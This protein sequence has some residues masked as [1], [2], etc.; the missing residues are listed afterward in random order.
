MTGIDGSLD[1]VVQTIR[2]IGPG[3]LAVVGGS[4][5]DTVWA[6]DPQRGE[7]VR[8]DGNARRVVGR[9][10]VPG[11]PTRLAATD[12]AVWVIGT[13]DDGGSLWR[14]D[15]RTNAVVTRIRLA[16][17]PKRVVLGAGSVW[18]TGNRRS[19]G[20]GRE[21]GGTVLRIDPAT[22]RVADRIDLGDVAADGIVVAHGLVWVAASPTA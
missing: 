10:G 4:M 22:N 21:T 11:R 20:H 13:G 16:F 3:G 12:R 17:I 18:V 6:S 7:V 2:G 9:I 5:G 15:P 1:R 14:I 19:D 8:I